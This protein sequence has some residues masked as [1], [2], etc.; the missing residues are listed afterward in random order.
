M[1]CVD[2]LCLKE[3]ILD[4]EIDIRGNS[5]QLK[6]HGLFKS[7]KTSGLTEGTWTFYTLFNTLG[8]GRKGWDLAQATQTWTNLIRNRDFWNTRCSHADYSKFETSELHPSM[9]E[10][11]IFTPEQLE[12]GVRFSRLYLA[13]KSLSSFFWCV[14]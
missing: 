11:R 5:E 6:S 3:G 4:W 2:R 14:R 12:V 7:K 13:S 1:L 10:I 8:H 9:L